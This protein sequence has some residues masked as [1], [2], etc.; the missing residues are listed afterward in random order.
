[1]LRMSRNLR[2]SCPKQC[3]ER[4]IHLTKSPWARHHNLPLPGIVVKQMGT[5]MVGAMTCTQP[6]IK[7]N[8]HNKKQQKTVCQHDA[9]EF[10]MC[11]LIAHLPVYHIPYF[12]GVHAKVY[13]RN[14]THAGNGLTW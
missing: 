14:L 7:W 6:S 4:V 5:K 3:A 8:Y 11:S 2:T 1:M 12:L 13:L 10:R 9:Q